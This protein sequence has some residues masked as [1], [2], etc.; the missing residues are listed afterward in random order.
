M[1][2]AAWWGYAWLQP[3]N[4]VH[5]KKVKN[6]TAMYADYWREEQMWLE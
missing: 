6:V 1:H 3:W 2:E 5:N 4:Y